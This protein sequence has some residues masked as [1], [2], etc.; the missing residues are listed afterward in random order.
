[1]NKN[2]DMPLTDEYMTYNDKTHRYVLTIK[3]VEE[4]VGIDM[5][6]R[7][8]DGDYTTAQNL[9]NTI[10][11]MIS[12]K[13]YGYIHEFNR[14]NIQDKIISR[15]GEARRVIQEAMRYQVVHYFLVGDMEIDDTAKSCLLQ[16]IPE[17]GTTILYQ[18]NLERRLWDSGYYKCLNA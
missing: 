1:M 7:L 10:L 18:G 2:S 11:D 5:I 12:V 8:N 13:I 4:V 6:A 3:Y 15:S 9:A 17:I 14:S 16:D